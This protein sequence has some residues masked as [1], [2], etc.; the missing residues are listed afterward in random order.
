MNAPGKAADT[1]ND[2]LSLR[3][4]ELRDGSAIAAFNSSMAHETEGKGLIPAVVGAGV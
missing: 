4:G 1:M 3:K 2:Q